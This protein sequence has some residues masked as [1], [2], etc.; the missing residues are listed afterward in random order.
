MVSEILL[1]KT[2]W[3]I[4]PERKFNK[5][6]RPYYP[7][8]KKLVVCEFQPCG[9]TVEKYGNAWQNPYTNYAIETIVAKDYPHT[10]PML[11]SAQGV[12]SP[13]EDSYYEEFIPQ[14]LLFESKEDAESMITERN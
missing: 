8:P 1:D 6:G 11:L 9:Y 5:L 7:S 4:L 14:I 12:V 3:T 2:Y 10:I 13:G